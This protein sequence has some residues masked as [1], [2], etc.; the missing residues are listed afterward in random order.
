MTFNTLDRSEDTAFPDA[1]GLLRRSIAAGAFPGAVFGVL[2]LGSVLH[3]GAEGRFTYD[4]ESPAVAPATVYDVASVT[5]VIATTGVAMLLWQRGEL[6]LDMPLGELLPG[7][8]GAGDARKERVTL[9]LLLAHSSGLPGVVPFYLACSTAE[10]V[11]EAALTLPLEAEP[12]TQMVYSDP[13]FILLGRALEVIGG[14]P[15]DQ[16]AAALIWKP[17]G[18][19]HTRFR[20]TAA[21]Q[22]VIPPTE[23]AQGLR[24]GLIQGQVHDENCFVL[25]GV[26]G[27]AGVFAPAG[28]LLRFAE[29][30]LAPLRGDGPHLFTAEAVRLFTNRAELPPGSS[31]ALGWDTPSGPVS[32]SGSLFSPRSFGHLGFTG[33]SLWIDPT[34][35]TAVALLT[36]RTYPFRENRLI[37]EVRPDFHNA[38]M[39]QLRKSTFAPTR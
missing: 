1:A 28:D 22:A 20:P 35:D 14:A 7:F 6:R 12:G 24:N 11:L 30:L 16:L 33:T 39:K 2:S 5:K 29:A 27:H 3:I 36:N 19:V 25:G 13:G 17:L 9:R 34:I 15:L 38:V 18:M 21:A 4:A 10:Q 31:R 26:S 37:Q 32:S 8:F 23:Q